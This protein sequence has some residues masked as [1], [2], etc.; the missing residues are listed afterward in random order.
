MANFMTFGDVTFSRDAVVLITKKKDK[1]TVY[2]NGV[3]SPIT[4]ILTG[5][6]A[7]ELDTFFVD[8]S[9]DWLNNPIMG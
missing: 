3:S 5:D 4:L 9:N 1:Y 2:L 6:E 7:L 8:K